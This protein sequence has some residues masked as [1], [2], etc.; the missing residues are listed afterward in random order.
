MNCEPIGK[1]LG[2]V[3]GQ[4]RDGQGSSGI[5]AACSVCVCVCV[6]EYVCVHVRVQACI[7]SHA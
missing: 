3:V 5:E 4:P 6:S 1:P 7:Q 2:V